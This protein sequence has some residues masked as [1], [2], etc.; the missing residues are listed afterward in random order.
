[1]TWYVPVRGTYHVILKGRPG[2]YHFFPNRTSLCML[3]SDCTLASSSGC[4]NSFT[5]CTSATAGCQ[6]YHFAKSTSYSYPSHQ[7]V[8]QAGANTLWLKA[9]ELCALA[10]QLVVA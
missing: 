3:S 8:L 5:L 10:T 2:S 9:R 1:M 6:A 7:F 4:T